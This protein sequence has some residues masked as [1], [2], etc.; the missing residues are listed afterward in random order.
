MFPRIFIIAYFFRFVNPFCGKRLD[1]G[2]FCLYNKGVAISR[3]L[4]NTKQRGAHRFVATDARQ[5]AF[6]TTESVGCRH[7]LPVAVAS[8]R[9]RREQVFSPSER[10]E[11]MYMNLHDWLMAALLALNLLLEYIAQHRKR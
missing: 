10:E 3:D 1:S 11:V 6:A 9:L 2:R 4:G 8:S 5:K 7:C